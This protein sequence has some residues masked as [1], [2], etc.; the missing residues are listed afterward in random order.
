[1]KKAAA[2]LESA[3]ALS[4]RSLS[5]AKMIPARIAL[6]TLWMPTKPGKAVAGVS[7]LRPASHLICPNKQLKIPRPGEI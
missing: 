5:L 6:P 7:T 4:A 3:T 2:G 1:M